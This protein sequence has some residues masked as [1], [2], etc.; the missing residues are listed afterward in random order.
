MRSSLAPLFALLLLAC[1]SSF[2]EGVAHY[3][4]AEYPQALE[5]FVAIE[6]D[7]AGWPPRDRAHYALYRGLTHFGL[8]NRALAKEWLGRAKL[9]Y[10]ANPTIFSDADAGKL[11]SAWAHL[12]ND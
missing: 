4:R 5:R 8:G 12:P 9:A 10:D 11:N 1:T 7:V 3:G 2:G 6:D